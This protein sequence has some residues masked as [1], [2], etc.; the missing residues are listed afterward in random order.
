MYYIVHAL[1]CNVTYV[2]IQVDLAWELGHR[3]GARTAS[4]NAKKCA[5]GAI[6]TGATTTG[7]IFVFFMVAYFAQTSLNG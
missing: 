1:T 5:V 6:V 3:S 7:A 2:L 4:E